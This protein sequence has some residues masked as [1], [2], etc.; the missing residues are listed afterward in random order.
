VDRQL[1][2]RP[3]AAVA[4]E[5]PAASDGYRRDRTTWAAFGALFAFGFVNAVL[6]PAL[7]YIR[8]VEHISYLVGAFHQ[9]AYAVG[10]GLAGL[11]AARDR[12][13]LGRTTVIAA[14][15]TGAALAGLAV[16]YGGTPAI[17]I[18]AAFAMSLL[19]TS[20]VI[21]LWAVLADAHR[22]RRAVAMSEGEVSVSLA[23]ILTPLLMGA[24]ATTALSW[25]FA[26][27]I[28][29]ACVGLAVLRLW[30]APMP[31]PAGDAQAPSPNARSAQ[32]W[33]QPTL[34]IVF[35]IVALEFSLSFW[36][37]SY[38]SDDIGLAQ[39]VAVAA[40]SG[41]YAA[42]LV[43]RVLA[44][45]LARRAR[46]ERLLAAA[47]GIAL[48]GLPVLLIANTAAV[49]GVGIAI[50]GIGIGAMFPLTSAL[51][52]KASALSADGALG[53]VLAVAAPGQLAGPLIAGA[54]AQAAGL[55]AGLLILPV[56]TLI[57]AASLYHV[58]SRPRVC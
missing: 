22:T 39:D 38:L 20:G 27:L 10:G 5:A 7:P 8:E 2:A 24:L 52:V 11:L 1:A 50:A 53:Q 14:G 26:F 28:G 33:R 34:I 41:L 19:A 3:A 30:R 15:L 46:P 48:L 18:A 6:G 57:A 4:A 9:A 13:S 58:P 17:T 54:I 37:A 16:G 49:A 44:S 40:V 31:P 12:R 25:R 36:L 56:L 35:A 23:G 43:G 21:R 45:R 55:R 29:A 51:H 42:S 47:I 32:G